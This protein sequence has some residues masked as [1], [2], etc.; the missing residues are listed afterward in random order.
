M[1]KYDVIPVRLQGVPQIPYRDGVGNHRGVCMHATA[2]Y[3]R[4]EQ[5]DLAINEQRWEQNNW[6][7]AFVHY[8]ADY[9]TI[10][11]VADNDYISY[12][13]GG[14]NKYFVNIELC[15][16]KRANRFVESYNRWIYIAACVLYE[17]KLGVVDGETLVSHRWV[18]ENLGGS[19]QDPHA[20]IE[21][22]GKTWSDVVQDVKRVYAELE[23]EDAV[24]L[25]KD[26]ADFAIAVLKAY[27]AVVEGNVP[28][29]DYTHYVTN[30][31]RIAAGIEI[32]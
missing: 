26:V 32:E 15:Q 17:R 28:L 20:Y 23:G 1:Q 10:L 6:K 29:Q 18:T 7:S 27:W 24:K 8:F 16:T 14:G 13:C 9:T 22:H 4:G 31:I 11:D 3:G 21:S 5:E 25:N 12:G 19:H 2:N 30:E